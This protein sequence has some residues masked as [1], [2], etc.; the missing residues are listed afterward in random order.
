MPIDPTHWNALVTRSSLV[1][2]SVGK[3]NEMAIPT[4]GGKRAGRK[5]SKRSALNTKPDNEITQ[6]ETDKERTVSTKRQS[7]T[8]SKESKKQ[9]ESEEDG[10]HTNHSETDKKTQQ[11]TLSNMFS[12]LW[13]TTPKTL[14]ATGNDRPHCTNSGEDYIDDKPLTNVRALDSNFLRT[15]G[16]DDGAESNHSVQMKNSDPALPKTGIH[17]IAGHDNTEESDSTGSSPTRKKRRTK[18][19]ES[20]ASAARRKAMEVE[21]EA[22]RK[23]KAKAAALGNLMAGFQRNAKRQELVEAEAESDNV[24]T[25]LRNMGHTCFVNSVLQVLRMSKLFREAVEVQVSKCG[26]P[27]PSLLLSLQ[28]LMRDMDAMDSLGVEGKRPSSLSPEEFLQVFR[29]QTG[30]LFPAFIQHD[31]HE[32]FSVLL[33]NLDPEKSTRNEVVE[34]VRSKAVEGDD[35]VLGIFSGVLKHIT[36][37]SECETP[38]A[39]FEAFMELPFRLKSASSAQSPGTSPV[40]KTCAR[41]PST[42]LAIGA[43]K[44]PTRLRGQNKLE[45]DTCRCVQEARRFTR[46]E[47]LPPV[48]VFHVQRFEYDTMMRQRK[49]AQSI[50]VDDNISFGTAGTDHCVRRKAVYRLHGAIFHSGETTTSGH[51][52]SAVRITDPEI[53]Q[54]VNSLD[55]TRST[56][57]E[58]DLWIHFDDSKTR[59]LSSANDELGRKSY[60]LVYHAEG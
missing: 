31:A 43:L 8:A 48:V 56:Q 21:E 41:T 27:A 15:K 29:A 24:L 60:L 3:E 5:K 12:H 4:A 6:T 57:T 40:R 58:D 35:G 52:T 38:R 36:Q 1:H 10:E 55:V 50:V 51:Y 14:P 17:P 16:K 19:K 33:N 26:N 44:L 23:K 9:T 37:C 20:P 13:K 39:Q 7:Y 34:V 54:R 46:V 42:K 49:I 28:R 11:N 30:D 18:P 22:D 32:F 25:G 59:L 45:C 53:I 2:K 47:K